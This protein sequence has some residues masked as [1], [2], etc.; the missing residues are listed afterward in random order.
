MKKNI[1][2]T[3][4]QALAILFLL[5]I[6]AQGQIFNG[7]LTLSSQ[8]EVDNFNYDEIDGDL[9][10]TGISITNLNGLSELFT[11]RRSLRIINTSLTNLDPLVN[12]SRIGRPGVNN[13][14]LVV[15]GN[16]YLVRYCAL[17]PAAFNLRNKYDVSGNALI[18][19]HWNYQP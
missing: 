16:V 12:L 11:I 7:N 5:F 8:A 9:T 6:D 10:I 2:S 4:F 14:S 1:Y 19:H 13:D 18:Q 17:F 3:V 15:R